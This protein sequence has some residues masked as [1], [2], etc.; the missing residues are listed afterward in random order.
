MAVGMEA[1]IWSKLYEFRDQGSLVMELWPTQ[2]TTPEPK[3]I[4]EEFHPMTSWMTL[5][6][7]QIKKTLETPIK[8][9]S[10]FISLS[11][12]V[13]FSSALLSNTQG[14]KQSAISSP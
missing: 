7:L 8:V 12:Q 6:S 5:K 3:V 10:V 4:K 13:S 9:V 11:L 1:S 14:K 2:I